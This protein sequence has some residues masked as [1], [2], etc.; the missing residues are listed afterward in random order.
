MF[1]LFDSNVWISQVGLQS[2][3]GAAVRHFAKLRGAIVAIPEVVKLE[4]EEKLT[5][6]LLTLRKKTEGNYRQL[7]PYM[8]KLQPI[9]LPS[10]E[11][12]RK[13][14]ENIIPTFDIPSRH[15]PFNVDVARSSMMKLLRKIP[16]STREEQFRDG[17][18]WAHC[19][20]LLDEGDVYLVSEDKD[21]YGGKNYERG[22]AGELVDEMKK[23]SEKHRV[24]L[25]P[26]LTKLL[27]EIRISFPLDT[28]EIF[29]AV[30]A[31]ESEKVEELLTDHGFAL[32]G[33]TNGQ[34][35]CFATEEAQ[36]IYFTF[37]FTQPCQDVAE[38]E[39]RDGELQFKG[40]G[41]LDAETRQISEVR[42]S[43]ILLDYP[44][45]EAKSGGPSRGTTFASAHF[46]AP[47]VHRIRVPL[48]TT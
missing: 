45:W 34:V 16:P 23:R 25:V 2:G 33:S 13:T 36:R 38:I 11:D 42:L 20:E 7:L 4:V 41:F 22:L 1:I 48:D 8:R 26:D 18:I 30:K 31:Q 6:S 10:E 35:N 28:T 39:R 17:V 24:K 12:I 14:V 47:M 32:Y 15:M 5:E 43:R 3:D 9:P 29:N 21:F 40:F 44:D 27:E 37:S 46:N 19:L